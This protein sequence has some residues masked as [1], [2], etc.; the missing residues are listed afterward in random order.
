M[1]QASKFRG[2]DRFGSTKSLKV[3]GCQPNL[4]VMSR[5][6]LFFHKFYFFCGQHSL[7]NCVITIYANLCN[8]LSF[9]RFQDQNQNNKTGR[10]LMKQV[11]YFDIYQCHLQREMTAFSKSFTRRALL[12]ALTQSQQQSFRKDIENLLPTLSKTCY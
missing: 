3:D 1:N 11:L 4:Y 2:N 8:T 5:Q 12:K 9:E 10:I 7:M 6:L